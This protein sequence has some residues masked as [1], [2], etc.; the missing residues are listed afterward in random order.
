[1]AQWDILR[2]FNTSFYK[3]FFINPFTFVDIK[4]LG[5]VIIL[6]Y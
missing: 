5:S 3:T 4:T 1:M 6:E 2:V